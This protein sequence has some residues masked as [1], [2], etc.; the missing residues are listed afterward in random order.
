[1]N[2]I[3]KKCETSHQ[4]ELLKQ[5]L[6]QLVELACEIHKKEGSFNMGEPVEARFTF[7]GGIIVKY[8]NGD[9]WYYE[10]LELPFPTYGKFDEEELET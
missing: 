8:Q 2:L 6:R 7:G 5:R 10:N 3:I 1:M 4:R 9:S